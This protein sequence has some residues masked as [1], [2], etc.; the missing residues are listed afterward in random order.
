[1]FWHYIGSQYFPNEFTEFVKNPNTLLCDIKEKLGELPSDKV[2][3]I[4]IDSFANQLLLDSSVEF[5]TK[6]KEELNKLKESAKTDAII[7]LL[8]DQLTK[9]Q[10][11]INGIQYK[12]EERAK[13]TE[14]NL[15]DKPGFY[16]NSE[17]LR[18]NRKALTRY[19]KDAF[20]SFKNEYQIGRAHV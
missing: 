5:L 18:E 2:A 20:E 16:W 11:K 6:P 19:T 13:D 9:C 14:E 15:S 17:D 7:N 12:I 10:S 4:E 1:M 8:E 3:P